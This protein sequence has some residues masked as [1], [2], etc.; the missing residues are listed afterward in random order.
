MNLVDPRI[1][2]YAER[3]TTP[4]PP[5]I[6]ALDAAT[7]RELGHAPMLSGP[8]V[9]RFLETLAWVMQPRLVLEIGTFSGGS[10]LFLAAGMP[11]DARLIT[12]EVDPAHAAFA[13]ARLAHDP[14]IELREGPA[15]DTIAQV[16]QPVDLAFVDADKVSYPAY[17]DALLPKLAP[18]GLIVA[19]NM[20]RGGAV[21]DPDP[22]EGTRAVAAYN[23]RAATD[24]ALRSVLLTV[25]DGLTLIC[26]RD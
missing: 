20:L 13:R 9:G 25:R 5:Q 17:L 6:A 16:D 22:D 21:L 18:H 24:P 14:R 8:V 1:E 2:A 4:W 26:R 3:S 19:D 7:R 11:A 23:A 10:A 12:C 15:L